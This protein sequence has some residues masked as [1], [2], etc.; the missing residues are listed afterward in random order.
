MKENTTKDKL[1]ENELGRVNGDV[2]IESLND[3]GEV[4]LFKQ[5]G[6][7]ITD[8]PCWKANTYSYKGKEYDRDSLFE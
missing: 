8:A 2:W 4:D 6:V 7:T 5:S 3:K 1:T